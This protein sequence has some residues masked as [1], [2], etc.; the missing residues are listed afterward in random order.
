MDRINKIASGVEHRLGRIKTYDQGGVVG[1]D[2]N[3]VG[4]SAGR[5]ASA[6]GDKVIQ[7]LLDS[8]DEVTAP[9]NQGT[10]APMD[11]SGMAKL[12]QGI[13]DM[14]RP[15][16]NATAPQ[17]MQPTN[18]QL[19]P[20]APT[21]PANLVAPGSLGDQGGLVTK[22]GVIPMQRIQSG[23]RRVMDDGGT[24]QP[25]PEEALMDGQH[26][27]AI[28][29]TGERVLSREQA[30]TPEAMRIPYPSEQGVAAPKETL[31]GT[32]AERQAIDVDRKKA[33]G[34]GQQ[35]LV[36]LG[37]AKI[38]EHHLEDQP[39]AAPSMGSIPN[40]SNVAPPVPDSSA[41]PNMG[42][43]Q[44]P[45][46]TLGEQPVTMR[47]MN[48]NMQIPGLTP[49]GTAAAAP[50]QIQTGYRAQAAELS[51][52]QKEA[53]HAYGLSGDP[54]D[55]AK[56]DAASLA[57]QNLKFQN[58]WGTAENHPGFGGKLGHIAAAIG[59]VAG[60][61][62]APETMEMI[63]GTAANRQ[64]QARYTMGQIEKE[65]PE[66]TARE[67]EEGKFDKTLQ[68]KLLSG[69]ENTRTNPATGERQHLYENP[70]GST[71]WVAEGS[72][73][74]RVGLPQMTTAA[75][76]AAAPTAAQPEAAGSMANAP[77]GAPVAY[78]YGKPAGTG[79][80]P[81]EQL[82]AANKEMRAATASGDPTRIE[83][84]KA[85]LEDVSSVTTKMADKP[86]GTEGVKQYQEQLKTT[87]LNV[88]KG[89][90][91]VKPD[92]LPTDTNA[93]AADKVKDYTTSVNNAILADRADKAQAARE[94]EAA[95]RERHAD[96]RKDRGT[97]GYAED[98]DGQ[99]ILTN[100]F[101]AG[102]NGQTFEPSTPGDVNK[103]RA[104]TRQL[105]DVQLNTSRYTKAARDYDAANLSPQ[106]IQKDTD[107][108]AWIMNKSGFYDINASI[109][110]GGNIT[111]PMVTAAG[112]KASTLKKSEQYNAL[113]PQGKELFNGYIRTLASV[114][115]YQKALTGIG[116]SNKEMLD[117]EL[118]NIANPTLGTKVILDKQ[119]QFQENINRATEGFPKLP[120]MKKASQVKSETEGTYT[121]PKPA[122]VQRTGTFKG[123]TVYQLKN[124]T[125]VDASGKPIEVK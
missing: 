44:A 2:E 38:H 122:D 69:E 95:T 52:A 28:L 78:Q 32:P 79:L 114:P 85:N 37:I 63:P 46:P 104:A 99:T 98:K 18:A 34:Q 83:K 88:P 14:K 81:D 112:E 49:S 12:G 23:M 97:I 31:P 103:D 84:A 15:V 119:A 62:V 43:R 59:N 13:A 105:N 24:V 55:K 108:L 117:L 4:I 9:V 86:T 39:A 8:P 107:N 94:S 70:D 26:V 66:V 57:L 80:T 19:Y 65:T 56:A 124:G 111:L 82:I 90:A 64:A 106:I 45:V 40:L 67:S 17:Y 68:P 21:A 71:Q 48:P 61:I 91:P 96:E 51:K 92:I 101:D 73:P 7:G 76:T 89:Y 36:G 100:K 87:G 6:Q 72:A 41:L 123:Q 11:F 22:M 110:A 3:D 16:D 33:M 116:R 25:T 125:T 10:A 35:G 20:N 60:N 1:E 113:S 58:P 53:M 5:A 120:G 93:T 102:L 109:S 118:A 29:Q 42:Q 77:A 50:P 54:E 115:A 74:G 47:S 30:A 121:A 75:P 27:P